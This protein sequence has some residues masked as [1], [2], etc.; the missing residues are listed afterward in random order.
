MWCPFIAAAL[1]SNEGKNSVERIQDTAFLD[2]QET[3]CQ[4]WNSQTKDCGL[5]QSSN[6]TLV[7]IKDLLASISSTLSNIGD[8]VTRQTEEL[9]HY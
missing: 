8:D 7:E 2:C 4:M 6:R 3:K 5:K 9:N 1:I